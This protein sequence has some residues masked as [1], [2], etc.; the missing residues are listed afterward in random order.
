LENTWQIETYC[1]NLG[2]KV[3]GKI[4]FDNVVT[5]ALTQ[6]SPVVEYSNGEISRQ[7]ELLWKEILK[8]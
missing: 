1:Q 6:N 7:I 2:I 4:P 3:V 5:E 8:E